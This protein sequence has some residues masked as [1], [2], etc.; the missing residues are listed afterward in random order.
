MTTVEEILIQKGPTVIVTPAATTVK[1]A[2]DKMAEAKVG[3]IVI[4]EYPKILGIFT[5]R[6]L[7][8]RVVA[9]GRDP[10]TT[11][12]S[13]V[14]SSPVASCTPNADVHQAARAMTDQHIR[15]L[16]V[17]D[18]EQ[19]VGLLSVRDVLGHILA[20]QTHPPAQ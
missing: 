17:V 3:S 11:P 12:V 8:V 18:K 19:I 16:V 1:E 4:E 15:H 10:A 6:D 14:M 5:E 20:E 7:L 2:A 9:Q 13:L